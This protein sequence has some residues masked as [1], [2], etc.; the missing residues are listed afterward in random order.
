[1]SI[2]LYDTEPY[3]RAFTARVLSCTEE[4]DAWAVVLDRTAFYP[5]GGGQPGDRGSLGS[6]RVLD[7]RERGG[8]VV[9][10]CASPLSP[11]ESVA[12]E[13]DWARRFDHMCQHS[14]E[15]L[16]S[17]MICR[18]FGCNNVGFHLGAE[19]VVIDFDRPVPPEA[20]PELEEAA[21]ALIRADV[22][23]EVSH[24]GG[25]ALAALDYR[26]KKE[27]HGDVRIVTVPGAD[28]CAC[29]GT[30]VRRTGELGLIK[31]LNM[32]PFR[33]GVRIE[34]VSGE[35]AYRYVC[36]VTAQ[37]HAVS[38]ALSAKETATA[39]AVA[40]MKQEL[41]E[42]KYRLVGTENR[43]FAHI[44]AAHAGEACPLLR[45]EGLDPEALRRLCAAMS[46][47]GAAE[48]AVFS[49]SDEGGYRYAVKLPPERVKAMNQAL[50][51]RGGGRDGFAQGSVAARWE[52][53]EGFFG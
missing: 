33:E 10:L 34:M 23:I 16:V 25:E 31:L 49:G 9:H 2:R 32:K 4:K 30:H 3:L 1:M 20:L 42:L 36:A 51:G 21:N 53:I 22:A 12:G 38:V 24:P 13:I 27:L 44:A 41:A 46:E 6:A 37:N 43:L 15:H 45:E 28:C 7:T 48:A 18:R 40:R 47:A 29:C 50:R 5:E 52:E 39:E 14:G 26:S 11:G 19:T 35:R 17:G 8:E